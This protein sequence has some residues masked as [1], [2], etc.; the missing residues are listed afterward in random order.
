MDAGWMMNLGSCIGG[1]VV[2]EVSL[3]AIM[4]ISGKIRGERGSRQDA[5]EEV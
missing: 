3:E 4:M 2:N 5:N 1:R